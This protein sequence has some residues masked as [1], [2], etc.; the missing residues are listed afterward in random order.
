MKLRLEDNTLRLRLSAADVQQFGQHGRVAVTVPLGLGPTDQ[1]V[2]AL[3]HSPDPAAAALRVVYA[4]GTL[5]VQVPP[6][7]A[8]QWVSSDQVGFSDSVPVAGGQELRVLVEKDL[9][10]KH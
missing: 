4:V 7:L 6:A 8:A 10:C 2:Y 5:H 3:E 9:D 1:L